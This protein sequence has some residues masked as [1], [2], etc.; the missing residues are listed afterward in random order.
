[1][2]AHEPVPEDLVPMPEAALLAYI[3]ASGI[4]RTITRLHRNDMA[5]TLA[6]LVTVYSVTDAQVRRVAPAELEGGLF[7]EGGRVVQFRDGREPIKGLA[8][9]R[10]ALKAAVAALKDAQR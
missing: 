6:R 3:S 8:V 9:P 10:Q 7:T 1:M 5:E 4:D 2:N